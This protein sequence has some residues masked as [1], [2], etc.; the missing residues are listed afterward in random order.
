MPTSSTLVSPQQ[1]IDAAK[2]PLL[3]FN[4]KDWDAVRASITEDFVYDEVST[5][6]RSRGREETVSL[7]Q[8]WAQAFPDARATFDKELATG[9]T[10]VVEVTWRG[11]H[12]G[13]L[14]TPAGL[15]D[16]TGKRIDIRACFVCDMGDGRIRQER[17]YFDM[18]T[19]LHQI[20]VS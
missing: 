11:T 9:D 20:A 2:A 4:E 16:A 8:S 17:H 6:R 12:R 5:G 13:A 10:V 19:L 1:L 3:A 7:W 18:A 15:I 14:Q